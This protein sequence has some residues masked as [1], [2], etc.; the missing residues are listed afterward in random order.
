VSRHIIARRVTISFNLGTGYSLG[1]ALDAIDKVVAK[2][3][4]PA[5]VTANYLRT[6]EE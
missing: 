6:S 3:N 5:S 1:Q 2:E 4:F